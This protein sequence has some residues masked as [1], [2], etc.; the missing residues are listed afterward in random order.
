[1]RAPARPAR[2]TSCPSIPYPL[3]GRSGRSQPD[4]TS[5]RLARGLPSDSR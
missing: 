4:R 5:N 3:P 2:Q 1:L